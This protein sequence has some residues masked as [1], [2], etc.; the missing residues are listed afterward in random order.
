MQD[1]VQLDDLTDEEL[2]EVQEI[3]LGVGEDV[4]GQDVRKPQYVQPIP[5]PEHHL[6][7]IDAR[8][9]KEQRGH[10]ATYVS[11]GSASVPE[12]AYFGLAPSDP[13]AGLAASLVSMGG[14]AS[15][16]GSMLYADHQGDK[17]Q[18]HEEALEGWYIVD[19]PLSDL[20]AEQTSVIQCRDGLTDFVDV[21]LPDHGK[22]APK[23][24][25]DELLEEWYDLGDGDE[26]LRQLVG[27][28]QRGG[29]ELNVALYAEGRHQITFAVWDRNPDE[30]VHEADSLAYKE[31]IQQFSSYIS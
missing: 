8:K 12:I 11:G 21:G 9:S 26:E 18:N 1:D 4:H 14:A 3:D 23:A 17:R 5:R 13:I 31:N 28:N 20:V 6:W 15:A 25:Y 24:L 16:V 19:E 27:V 22:I 2:I 30:Y 7:E 29:A 10:Y